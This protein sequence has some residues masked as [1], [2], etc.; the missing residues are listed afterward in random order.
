[1]LNILLFFRERRFAKNKTTTETE[2]SAFRRLI[3]V[4]M[5]DL[6]SHIDKVIKNVF[7]PS[8]TASILST[9][10]KELLDGSKDSSNKCQV[11]LDLAVILNL[12]PEGYIPAAGITQFDDKHKQISDPVSELELENV[13][14][15]NKLASISVHEATPESKQSLLHD[16]EQMEEKSQEKRLEDFPSSYVIDRVDVID[17][18]IEES[19]TTKAEIN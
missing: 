4:F 9:N 2:L 5:Q 11:T 14:Q 7:P 18:E 15:I 3:D 16:T 10:V 1:M 17:K 19:K 8:V 12:L 13:S 6:L